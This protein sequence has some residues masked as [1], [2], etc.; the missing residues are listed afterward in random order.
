MIYGARE[1]GV[2]RKD[3]LRCMEHKE[4]HGVRKDD[5]CPGVMISQSNSV[6]SVITDNSVYLECWVDRYADG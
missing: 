6:I 3:P 4:R 2:R 1:N 5:L